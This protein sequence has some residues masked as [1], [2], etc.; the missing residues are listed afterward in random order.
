MSPQARGA[1]Y[2][3]G[4]SVCSVCSLNV[5]SLTPYDRNQ[6]PLASYY[7]KALCHLFCT[8]NP[9]IMPVPQE[10]ANHTSTP[11]Y[12]NTIVPSMCMHHHNFAKSLVV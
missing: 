9:F 11:K 12:P 5:T 4:T 8:S 1:L 2:K 10:N 6:L 7:L 3:L